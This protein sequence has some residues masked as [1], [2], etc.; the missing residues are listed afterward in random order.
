L[1]ILFIGDVFGSPGRRWLKQVLPDL[2][3]EKKID[4]C[5]ANAENSAAGSGITHLTAK[6]VYAAGVDLITMGNHTWSKREVHHFIE[7]DPRI[8]RPANYAPGV[9]GVGFRVVETPKGKV[10]IINLIG[11]VFMDL[12][13]CPFR[14]ADLL[15]TEI[16]KETK[17]VIVDFHAEATS[18]KMALAH[19]LDGRVSAVIGTH[20]HVQTA[21]ESILP[22]GTGY[23]T[24]VGMTGPSQGIIG[25]RSD[26]IVEK[27]LKGLPSKFE[28]SEG[29]TQLNA[30][31]LEV[32]ESKGRTLHIERIKKI[33]T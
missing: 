14:T 19:Y 17:V 8:I 16:K 33:S 31:V 4:F 11:R 29:E 20:T 7:S 9:P 12:V 27:F 22:C 1:N 6:E 28:V 5:I 30:V 10:G 13:D 24:D 21:D 2:K 3:K 15:L 25:V 23:I 26:I 18:E 32:M